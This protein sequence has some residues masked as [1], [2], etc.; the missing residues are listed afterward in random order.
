LYS[1][2]ANINLFT[3]FVKKY[4]GSFQGQRIYNLQG[5]EKHFLDDDITKDYFVIPSVLARTKSRLMTVS[6]ELDILAIGHII[7]A[8]IESRGTEFSASFQSNKENLNHCKTQTQL[9]RRD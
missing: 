2:S 8:W 7:Y 6:N 3:R 5:D 4:F 9:R 1:K